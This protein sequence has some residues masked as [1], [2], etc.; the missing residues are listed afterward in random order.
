M[1][2]G[3]IKS[4]AAVRYCPSSHRL[5]FP[6]ERTAPQTSAAIELSIFLLSKFC[7][8]SQLNLSLALSSSLRAGAFAAA[9]DGTS[10][11]SSIPFRLSEWKIDPQDTRSLSTSR[12]CAT[13]DRHA[14]RCCHSRSFICFVATCKYCTHRYIHQ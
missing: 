3:P 11:S 1:V 2:P 12:S 9:A 14:T 4:I 8:C 13:T 10:S 5:V 6:T 7:V